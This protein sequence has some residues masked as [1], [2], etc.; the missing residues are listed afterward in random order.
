MKSKFYK[1]NILSI[2]YFKKENVWILT[3]FFIFIVLTTTDM[4]LN[5]SKVNIKVYFKSNAPP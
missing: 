2:D 1:S 3:Y 5:S 4:L